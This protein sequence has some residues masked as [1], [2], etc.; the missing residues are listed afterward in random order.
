VPD[1]LV[2]NNREDAAADEPRPPL[3][4]HDGAEAGDET[5]GASDER[6]SVG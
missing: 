4:D 5:V 3:A 6:E 2:G 1:Q